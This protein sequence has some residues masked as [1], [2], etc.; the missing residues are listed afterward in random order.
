MHCSLV[1]GNISINPEMPAGTL[2]F[3]FV[4]GNTLSHIL[5]KIQIFREYYDTL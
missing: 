2:Y 5:R 1:K 3:L 4:V